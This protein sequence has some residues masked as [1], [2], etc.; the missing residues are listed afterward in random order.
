[1]NWQEKITLQIRK[2][3]NYSSVKETAN[4]KKLAVF[5]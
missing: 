3:E 1:M 5:G 4:R 2:E